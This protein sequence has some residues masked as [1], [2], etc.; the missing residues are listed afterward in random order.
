[1]RSSNG[2]RELIAR[3]RR[4]A[5]SLYICAYI[6]IDMTTNAE[7]KRVSRTHRTT[8]SRTRHAACS[9]LPQFK[10]CVRVC[11]Y[12]R[13]CVCL[14]VCKGGAEGGKRER[15][16]GRE[17]ECKCVHECVSGSVHVYKY[18]YVHTHQRTCT[19]NAC[20][21]HV[22][23]TCDSTRIEYTRACVYT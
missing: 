1:M 21:Y 17:R 22:Y 12:V 20:R 13:M 23:I 18:E 6:H 3:N 8:L 19:E 9:L 14:C 7:L 16:G 4:T 10:T 11:V 2:L 5:C 15:E